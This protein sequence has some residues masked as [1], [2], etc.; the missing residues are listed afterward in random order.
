[1][2]D[3]QTVFVHKDIIQE[4]QITPFTKS[5]VLVAAAGSQ[6]PLSKARELGLI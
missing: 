1:M 3:E 4:R 5:K 2:E 6:I